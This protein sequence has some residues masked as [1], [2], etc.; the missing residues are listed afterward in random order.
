MQFCHISNINNNN[1]VFTPVELKHVIM[2][3][4]IK[5]EFENVR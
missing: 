1:K 2:P 5:T 4:L 3:K